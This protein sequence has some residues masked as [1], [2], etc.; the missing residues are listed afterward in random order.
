[1]SRRSEATAETGN[2]AKMAFSARLHQRGFS[3][4]ETLVVVG[5]LMVV[6]A[7]AIP[8]LTNAINKARVRSAAVNLSALVQQAR[9]V[10][11]QRNTT[12]PFYATT[13]GTNGLSGA[14]IS[15][16]AATCPGAASWAAGDPFLVYGSNVTNSTNPP[17][18]LN[19]GYGLQG[20]GTTLYLTPLGLASNTAGGASTSN[21]WAFYVT[22]GHG[23]W[24]AV[25]VSPMGRSKV[26]LYSGGAWH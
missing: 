11:E 20:A 16:S 2:L 4:V 12:V 17:A 24:G 1:M 26:W 14:F 22:D 19:P 15:C 25:S 13:A 23:N 5:I 7:I 8:R 3:M 9:T 6:S 18:A 10:A 21:G